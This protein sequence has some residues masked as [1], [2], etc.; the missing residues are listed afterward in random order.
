MKTISQ[1]SAITPGIL[2]LI[3]LAVGVVF[4]GAIGRTVPMLSSVHLDI[5]LLV[6][7]GMALYALGGIG[8]AAPAGEWSNPLSITGEVLGALILFVTLAVFA[9]WR[10]PFIQ[11]E[12]QAL[13]AIAAMIAL[14]IA[15]AV[16][17][18]L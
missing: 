17:H 10:L 1:P 11:G 7:L 9:G 3:S 4:F 8:R 12:R 16:I 13:L 18:D 6:V 5:L 14:K 15:I 2:L